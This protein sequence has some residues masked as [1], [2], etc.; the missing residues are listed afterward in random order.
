MERTPPIPRHSV[1]LWFPRP[2]AL[3]LG[4]PL[5]G[6]R[7]HFPIRELR[8]RLGGEPPP[9]EGG[10]DLVGPSFDRLWELARPL[11][12]R[13]SL[14]RD[15][16]R[17]NWRFHARP[18]RSYRMVCVEEPGGECAAWAVFSLLGSSALVMDFLARDASAETFEKLWRAARSEAAA[19]GASSL[20]FWE[21]PGG[22]WRPLLLE[23]AGQPGGE[24]VDAGFGFATAVVHE[25]EALSRFLRNLQLTASLY[26]DR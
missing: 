18:D 22:P 20:V 1:L 6:Y 25:E 17:V 11:V 7:A 21:S 23:K 3:E 10:A 5:V 9:A 14:V 2:H 12:D 8:F 16:A 26:D 24:I 19:M 15:R 13:A 4:G